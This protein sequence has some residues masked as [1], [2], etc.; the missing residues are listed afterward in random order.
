MMPVVAAV[1]SWHQS[2]K[3]VVSDV[4][5]DQRTYGKPQ[6]IDTLK[7]QICSKEANRWVWWERST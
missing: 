4:E 7:G 2:I 1:R 5:S 3:E 6:K